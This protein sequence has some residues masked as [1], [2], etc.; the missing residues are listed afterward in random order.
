MSAAGSGLALAALPARARQAAPDPSAAALDAIAE[1]FLVLQPE[2]ATGLGIDTGARAPLK[3]R[4]TDRSQAGRDKEAAWLRTA[5]GRIETLKPSETARTDVEVAR[6]AYSTALEGY[7]FPYGAI[8][9]GGWRNGPYV[10]AQN[11]GAYLDVPKFLDSSHTVETAADAEAYLARLN[12]FADQLDGET[13]RLE[14][15]RGRGIVASDVLM[16]KTLDGIRLSRQGQPKDWLVVSSLAK[17]TA[18]ISGNWAARAEK[19]AATRVAPALDRQIAELEQHARVATADAGVWKFRDGDAYYAWALRAS[20]TTRMSPDEVHAMGRAELARLQSEMDGILKKLGYSS[21]SVGARMIALAKDPRYTFPNDDAGRAQIMALIQDR[22]ADIR[23]RLPRAFATL[24]DGRVEVRRIAPAE[25][26]GA[27]GAYGGAGSIDGK[28]PGRFWIN[29]RTTDLHTKYS[30]PTLTY[31][32]SI[33]G[34]VW[35]GEYTHKLP[36]IRTLM[37]FNAYSEGW[38][39]YAEQLA[40]ELGVYDDDPVGRLGYLQSIAF[41]ACRLVVD[42][43]LHAKRWTRAQAIQWFAETNG[44]GLDEVTSEVDRYCAWPGQACGYKVGHSEINRLRMASQQRL[45]DRFDFRG[46]N[47]VV[48]GGGGVPL[49]VLAQ[50]VERWEAS[51]RG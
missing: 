51:R 38:A 34:H 45:G 50:N 44:S 26:I 5:L 32:E 15:A 37:G 12:A 13:G 24:V 29:L 49:N 30:L 11:M 46:Y 33:P 8:D 7:G 14:S 28:V 20:T 27:P 4:V 39:L 17:R 16:K 22:I 21:G 35:Q 42:T 47:D 25:E 41:R 2:G 19:I 36:L 18:A 31:H 48:V 9:I 6:T 1:S 3:S 43:G 23:T 40:G 10:V